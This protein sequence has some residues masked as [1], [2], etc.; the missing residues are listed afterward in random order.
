MEDEVGDERFL[1]RRGKTFDQLR[2]KSPDE[3]HGVRHEIALPVVLEPPRRRVERLEQTVVHGCVGTGQGIEQRRLPDVRIPRERNRRR[4]RTH[5]LLPPC[6]ALALESPKALLEQR[7]SR[8]GKASVGLQ[9]ALTW[10]PGPDA[11]AE[12]LQVLPHAAHAREVVLELCQLD[13]ELAL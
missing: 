4:A 9:L 10:P 8:T 2:R 7:H 11:T 3:A 6:R 13:L 12:P 1:E 5:A